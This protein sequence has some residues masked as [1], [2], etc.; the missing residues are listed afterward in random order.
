MGL[1]GDISNKTP[2]K[3]YEGIEYKEFWTGIGKQKLDELERYLV[4]DLLPPSGVRIIDLGCGYGRLSDCYMNRFE[5]TYYFDGSLSLL[6]QAHERLG[7]GVYIAGDINQL[8]F[9]NNS[10]DAALMVRVFHHIRDSHG[11]LSEINRILGRH[12]ALVFNFSNKYNISRLT[13]WIF[14]RK[15]EPPLAYNSKFED[16]W[17]SQHHPT[18]IHHI[19]LDTGFNHFRYRGAGIIDKIAAIIGPMGT[20]LPDGRR[21]AKFFGAFKIAPWIF[22][23]ASSTNCEPL[24]VGR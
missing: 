22:C 7:A 13:R 2:H 5:N 15:N 11:C 18:Y 19:L 8:P 3:I 10:F 24:I 14:N 9:K 20:H 21:I 12:G 16:P 6:Q 17:F 4:C 23:S 1:P